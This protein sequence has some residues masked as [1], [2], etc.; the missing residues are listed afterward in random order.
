[1]TWMFLKRAAGARS[2]LSPQGLVLAFFILGSFIGIWH[3]LPMLNVILDEQ[4]FVGGVLRAIEVKSLLPLASEVPYG[5]ITFYLNYLLQIPFL[6]ALFAWKGFSIVALKT[7]LVLNPEIAYLVPRFLSAILASLVAILYDR[8]LRSEGLP[9]LHRFAVLSVIFCTVIGAA[10]L[11]TGK[12]WVLSTILAAASALCTYVALKHLT[13]GSPGSKHRPIFFGIVLAFAAWA[14]FPFYGIFLINVPIL[15]YAFRNDAIRLRAAGKAIFA[16]GI[17]FLA[18]VA[19]N[20]HNI[21]TLVVNTLTNEVFRSWSGGTSALSVSSLFTSLVFHAEQVLVAFPLVVVVLAIAVG[22]RAIQ[23]KLLFRLSVSYAGL[24]FLAIVGVVPQISDL[25]RVLHYLFPLAFFFAGALASVAYEKM[26]TVLWGFGA[27]QVVVFLYTLYLLSVPTT[28]NK[29][30]TYIEQNFNQENILIIN[31]VVEL[32]LPLNKETSKFL[33]DDTC[34]SKCQY[35]R[36]S[37]E[38]ADFAPAMMTK[39]SKR[40]AVDDVSYDR[41]FLVTDTRPTDACVSE[42]I[43]TFES[44]A[45]DANYVNVEYNLGN[46]FVTDFWHLSRLGKNLRMYELSKQC[47][48]TILS[49]HGV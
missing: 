41:V 21:Y 24:Y 38:N 19:V 4:Y 42:P 18:V 45:S 20:F 31:E 40:D 13:E 30:A 3:A 33:R 6:L 22:V 5:T 48:A 2:A 43:M 44:G 28:F 49:L 27:L 8:F 7:Y 29:A 15:L 39:L 12:M 9:L 34:A 11:H 10:T 26:R 23:N 1:M 32:N 36:S 16:G 17:V 37:A 25:G 46:Y 35:W 14:N 47:A